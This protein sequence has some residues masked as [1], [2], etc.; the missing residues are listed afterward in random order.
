MDVV[1]SPEV[2]R[3]TSIPALVTQ[4]ANPRMIP[5]SDQRIELEG[6]RLQGNPRLGLF[7]VADKDKKSAGRRVC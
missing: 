3:N 6:S 5:C 7:G 2:Q 1:L 4:T